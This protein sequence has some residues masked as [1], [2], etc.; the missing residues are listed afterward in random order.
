M[1]S[2]KFSWTFYEVC[3]FQVLIALRNNKKILGR[4]KAFDRCVSP[5]LSVISR[6]QACEH[7]AGRS[8]V[9]VD[10]SAEDGQGQENGEAGVERPVRGKDL[11]PRRLRHHHREQSTFTF[12]TLIFVI[13][14]LR[15]FNKFVPCLFWI[16]LVSGIAS[17]TN[18]SFSRN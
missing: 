9:A 3:V 18:E 4:I 11:P 10:R 17:S 13:F 7:D 2:F 16:G 6:F 8:E 12:V 1:F 14:L 15:V 5:L